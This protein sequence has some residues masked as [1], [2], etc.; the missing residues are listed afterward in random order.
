MMFCFMAREIYYAGIVPSNR[1][2]VCGP[3][4]RLQDDQKNGENEDGAYDDDSDHCPR[5]W[6]T[7]KEKWTRW[8][9]EFV[10]L[11]LTH[12]SMQLILD[13]KCV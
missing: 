5:T 9:V 3:V 2:A 11:H 1:N 8:K 7:E 4:V 12:C 13:K 10:F 6:E